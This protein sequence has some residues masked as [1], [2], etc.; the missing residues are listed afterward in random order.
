VHGQ[1]YRVVATR[2]KAK[3][4]GKK[5]PTDLYFNEYMDSPKKLLHRFKVPNAPFYND[6]VVVNFKVE[7]N[8]DPNPEKTAGI[9]F[10]WYHHV[11]DQED[12]TKYYGVTTHGIQLY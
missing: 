1:Y 12:E 7:A 9:A 2:A 8:P 4:G 5:A 10:S 6:S 11:G 3:K